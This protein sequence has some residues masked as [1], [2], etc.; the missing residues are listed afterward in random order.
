MNI[1]SILTALLAWTPLAAS[2]AV[3]EI[4]ALVPNFEFEGAGGILHRLSDYKGQR[5]VVIAWF[6]R[7]FTPG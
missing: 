3:V 6:P 2:A 1:R 7:A 5:G 4:G